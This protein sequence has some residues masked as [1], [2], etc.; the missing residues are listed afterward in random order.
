VRVLYRLGRMS[1]PLGV[2][3][4]TPQVRTED[5]AFEEQAIEKLV[6]LIGEATVEGFEPTAICG[7]SAYISLMAYGAARA[8]QP[9]DTVA[10]SLDERRHAAFGGVPAYYDPT[11]AADAVG[12]VFGADVIGSSY[13][14]KI[15]KR[16]P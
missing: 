2:D 16:L 12:L 5:V 4:P 10:M 1:A 7:R 11:M 3:E 9:I 14:E 6:R 13:E 15:L 8:G